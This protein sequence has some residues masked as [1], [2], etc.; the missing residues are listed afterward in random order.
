MAWIEVIRNE[1]PETRNGVALWLGED[2]EAYNKWSTDDLRD[3]PDPSVWLEADDVDRLV[4]NWLRGPE[5]PI[6][7]M[8]PMGASG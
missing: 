3:K 8:G 5:G 6:G 2:E 7:P 4:L 1:W